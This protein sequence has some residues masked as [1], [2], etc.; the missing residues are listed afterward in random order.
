MIW[1]CD[2]VCP[3]EDNI[4]IKTNDKR[5]KFQQLAFEMGERRIG[6][7]VI[8]VPVIIGCL[9]GGIALTLKEV[10]QLFNSDRL[11]RKVVGTMQ[12]TILMD[13]ETLMR[14]ILWGLIQPK[15]D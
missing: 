11:T 14:K 3:Q 8:V 2:M 13:S 1:L 7:K 15:I 10:K 12:K 5:T 9:G 4:N 6:Y